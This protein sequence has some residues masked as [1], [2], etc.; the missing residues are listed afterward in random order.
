LRVGF[1]LLTLIPG[2]LGGSESYARGLLGAF[3][4][5]ER[6]VA[7]APRRVI[8]E[9]AG[10]VRPPVE[11][12]DVGPYRCGGRPVTRA[13]GM[14]SARLAPRLVARAVPRDLDAVHYPL[15]VPIPRTRAPAVVTLHDV[16]HLE[17]PEFFSRA[18][19]AHRRWAYDRAA[20]AA[21]RVITVSEHG[22]EAAINHLGLDA[23]RVRAIHWG[24]D[25]E[26]FRPGSVDADTAALAGFRLPERF[27]LYPAN[28]WTH[29]NHDRLLEALAALQDRDLGLVLT[30][31]ANG[32]LERLRERA[33]SLGLDGRVQHLGYV[34]PAAVPALMRAAVALVFPSL[35]EG[36]G[37]PPVEAM[38]CGCPVASST[39]SSLPE[40]CGGAAL[41]FDPRD[42]HAIA[43]AIDVISSD[44]GLRDRLR[45]AGLDHA[46]RFT[47]ERAARQH[48]D[49][50]RD[51]VSA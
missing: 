16:Q 2:R 36:F 35:Y 4:G 44:E 42:T 45:R 48:L 37:G 12:R 11:L 30:G 8:D 26:R 24:V 51:A 32:R 29:K 49:V 43:A 46:E 33:V 10:L 18:E 40:V 6:I 50:Y 27:L 31:Q 17:V 38:A 14:G 23:A 22:R 9:C 28:L 15:T 39:A 20:R 1:S 7:L 25:H 21:A 47:W 19:R 5:P 13:I 3:T 41:H 34:S